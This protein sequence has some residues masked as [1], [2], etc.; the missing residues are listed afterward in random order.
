MVYQMETGQKKKLY[1]QET[2]P[3]TDLMQE[4]VSGMCLIGSKIKSF[5]LQE[6][7]CR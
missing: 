5:K 7:R 6:G 2:I 3:D 1:I 4:D